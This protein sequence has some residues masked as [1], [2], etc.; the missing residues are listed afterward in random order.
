MPIETGEGKKCLRN[1]FEKPNL[2]LWDFPATAEK[3]HAVQNLAEALQT[4]ALR[5]K[6]P[7]DREIQMEIPDS[8]KHIRIW[9]RE[10]AH[11]RLESREPLTKERIE[12][13]R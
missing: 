8:F 4:E 12:G 7:V 3:G 1:R 9:P 10:R 5:Y 13:I 11:F 6:L 2:G